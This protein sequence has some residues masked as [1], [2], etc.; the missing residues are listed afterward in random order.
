ML[1]SNKWNKQETKQRNQLNY[2]KQANKWRN[3]LNYKTMSNK[4]NAQN[5]NY[6]QQLN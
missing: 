2:N 5:E 6:E 3:I 1:L 4:Q